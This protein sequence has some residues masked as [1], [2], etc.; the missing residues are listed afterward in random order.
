[1][2][3]IGEFC[4][5]SGGRKGAKGSSGGTARVLAAIRHDNELT[6]NFI[7]LGVYCAATVGL[8]W[9]EASKIVPAQGVSKPSPLQIENSLAALQS[10]N[11]A[12][13][14]ITIVDDE[15]RGRYVRPPRSNAA[16]S[17]NGDAILDI[18]SPP[19]KKSKVRD[20]VISVKP[21]VKSTQVGAPIPAS[22]GL[23]VKTIDELLPPQR[24]TAT[25]IRK[26]NSDECRQILIALG[27]PNE[28]HGGVLKM[29][30]V[31]ANKFLPRAEPDKMFCGNGNSDDFVE[32][33]EEFMGSGQGD[34][35]EEEPPAPT[36]KLRTQISSFDKKSE[37]TDEISQQW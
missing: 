14:C 17:K 8:E 18:S 22:D 6:S 28:S 13:V 24:R 2:I 20:K 7:L 21:G 36:K 34:Q 4:R 15:N 11:H 23:Q 19:P 32:D 27:E 3:Q 30:A 33:D 29:R 37:H 5:V 1:M 26:L 12:N 9:Y 31:I 10:Y 25:Q 16:R 35:V